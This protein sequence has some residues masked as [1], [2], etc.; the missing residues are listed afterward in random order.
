MKKEADV[1]LKQEYEIASYLYW[2]VSL[3]KHVSRYMAISAQ[4]CL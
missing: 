4:V 2:D 1:G 3:I